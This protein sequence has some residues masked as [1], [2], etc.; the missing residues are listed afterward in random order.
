[1][2]SKP[3]STLAIHPLAPRLKASS[4]DLQSA[5]GNYV[6]TPH[7]TALRLVARE[8]AMIDRRTAGSKD[9]VTAIALHG[10][11]G[12]APSARK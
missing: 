3:I 7:T 4:I 5:V 8:P 10:I 12:I 11:I 6:L 1:M 2:T 9:P